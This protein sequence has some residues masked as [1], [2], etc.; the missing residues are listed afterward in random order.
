MPLCYTGVHT[1]D[2]IIGSVVTTE[3]TIISHVTFLH[4][5]QL[6]HNGVPEY[7]MVQSMLIMAQYNH[8]CCMD[9]KVI[10]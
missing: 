9:G 6:L 1:L 4:V 8:E 10:S 7:S 3:P 5:S 2:I